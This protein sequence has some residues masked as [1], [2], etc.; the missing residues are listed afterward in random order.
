[1]ARKLWSFS[2]KRILED[3]YSTSTIK[4]LEEMLPG[5]DFDSI[6]AA[7]RRLKSHGKIKGGRT[8]DTRDRSYR[9]RGR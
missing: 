7:V 4:E 8:S 6:N 9:Q 3:Y 5:R 1:M 2:E